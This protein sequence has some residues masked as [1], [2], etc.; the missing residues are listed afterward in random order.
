M[1]LP[2]TTAEGV[3]RGRFGE[4]V[5]PPTRYVIGFRTASGRV[6]ALALDAT[7]TRLWFQPPSSP[8][9]DGVKWVPSANGN[10][11]LNGPLTVLAAADGLRVEVDSEAALNRFIDWYETTRS[12]IDRAALER[13]RHK[14]LAVHPDFLPGGFAASAG[15][16]HRVEDDYKRSLLARVQVLQQAEPRL[17]DAGLGEQIF[18]LLLG[19][20]HNL[21]GTFRT[22]EMLRV[23]R[24]DHP[25]VLEG[26]I[27]RLARS[28]EAPEEAVERFVQNTWPALSEGRDRNKPYAESRVLPTLVLALVR[29][30]DAIAVRYQLFWNAGTLLLGHSLF[31]NAPLS[32]AE[33]AN[34]LE[35]SQSIF[36]IMRDE[37]VWHPRDLFDVQGFIWV[38][39]RD[40]TDGASQ[41]VAET[42]MAPNASSP[43]NLILYGPPGTGKTFRTAVEAVR[44]CDSSV[45]DDREVVMAR[46]RELCGLG[47]I[48]FVT[49]HQSYSYEEFIEGLRPRQMSIEENASNVVGFTLVP[50]PGIFTRL[51]QSAATSRGSSQGHFEIGERRVFKMS[52]GEAANPNDDYL[53]DEAERTGRVLLGWG[54]KVDWADPKFES[55]D[56]M[57][58]AWRP[59]H[60]ESSPLSGSSSYIKFPYI[61]R[62]RVRLHDLIVVSKGNSFFRAI[63]EVIGPYEYQPRPPDVDDDKVNTRRVRWLWIDRAG[64]PVENIYNKNFVMGSLYELSRNDL[65]LPV[66]E[67]YVVTGLTPTDRSTP[68]PFVMIIDEINRANI[69]KVFGELITL[70]EPDK[71]IG[72]TNALTVKLP[73]S[74]ED[75]GVPANLHIIGTMNTADRSIAL[76]D[77]ALRRRFTFWEMLPEP[78]LL[79]EV[80]DGVPLRNLLRLMNERIEYLFDREHQIGHAFFMG[81]QTRADIDA[82]MR[83]KVIPL[84]SEYFYED[85]S[86]LALVLGDT[87]TKPGTGKFVTRFD[88][89]P[90]P[91]LPTNDYDDQPRTRWQVRVEFAADAYA[92]FQ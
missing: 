1:T 73:Y 85:W 12:S 46:Y 92:S 24:K 39:C 27:G 44:I 28:I 18:E 25:G 32:R 80:V 40:R 3:L 29:P 67:R 10:S 87:E 23:V 20:D 48:A 50:E 74:R 22:G 13:L 7:E 45:S 64:A 77:T 76:L 14:F 65:N 38:T 59:H 26:A 69:S 37:W 60:V 36:A 5:K 83:D 89:Q 17:D 9:I 47:Q 78:S 91:G 51:A 79:D 57:I 53:I 84:L 62:N 75:F 70:I 66:L 34:V 8:E 55:R 71:R 49:F 58:E 15:S 63:A 6:L 30:S 11:N 82:V 35:M 52:I 54:D 33:Y 72:A 88:L 19:R 41:P 16:F 61:L 90:P 56:A 21:L 42:A 2:V 43:M 81:C 68:L 31:A 86:K 4:P